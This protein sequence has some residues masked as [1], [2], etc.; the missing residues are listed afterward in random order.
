[1]KIGRKLIAATIIATFM[2]FAFCACGSDNSTENNTAES[3]DTNTENNTEE[4]TE[5]ST[6]YE[7]GTIQQQ[8]VMVN[9]NLYIYDDEGYVSEISEDYELYGEIAEENNDEYPSEELHASRISAGQKV[10]VKSDNSDYIYV[11]NSDGNYEK[12]LIDEN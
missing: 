1:M 6:G 11:Q 5:E 8:A 2:L 9:G 7:S 12:Y 10:Y 4:D 3:S